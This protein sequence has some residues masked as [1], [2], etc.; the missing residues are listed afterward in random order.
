MEERNLHLLKA[1]NKLLEKGE[2]WRVTQ[3]LNSVHPADA[4][5]ILEALPD[6]EQRALFEVWD[7][8]HSA[9]ALLEM[10]EKEQVEIAEHLGLAVISEILSEMP[11]DDAADLLGDLSKARAGEILEKI[12]LDKRQHIE[13]LLKHREDT[14]GGLMTPKFVSLNKNMSTQQAIDFFREQGPSAQ[15]IYYIFVVDEINRL[16]GVLSLRDLIIAEPNTIIKNIMDEKVIYAPANVDQ[17]EV[18]RIMRK[19]DLLA[20]PVVGDDMKLLGMITVDDIMDVMQNEA[21]EDMYRMVGLSSDERVSTPLFVSL[22]RRLPWLYFNL[23][24]AILA[25]WVVGLFESTIAKVVTLAVF[26]PVVAGQGGNAGT[27]TLTIIVR[28]LALGEIDSKTGRRALI[29][30]ASLGLLNGI[31]IG[32]VIALVAYLWKGIPALGLVI[33]LAMILNMIAAGISGVVVPL[34][35]KLFKVDPAVASAIFVTTVT[36][37]CG[38]F[39]FL[40]LATL[41]ISW[42]V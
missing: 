3:V 23:G 15:E 37:V 24:T 30:E 13:R 25:A 39:F 7:A 4:A 34:G 29:K 14:A 20:L 5:E 9:D 19:Y 32:V 42:L 41:F 38:F 10:D 17:E 40:G 12:E 6:E 35:L 16:V 33:G 8:D 18:A 21:T 1:I 2:R 22:R 31:A 11:A 28:S 26:L 36:D 27:Q